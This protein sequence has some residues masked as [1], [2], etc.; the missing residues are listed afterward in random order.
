VAKSI[1]YNFFTSANKIQYK[2]LHPVCNCQE[3]YPA[4]NCQEDYPVCNC[5]EDYPVCNC[6][7]DYLVFLIVTIVMLIV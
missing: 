3:D 7:E 1:N 4:C 6:Q 2:A 5:Q